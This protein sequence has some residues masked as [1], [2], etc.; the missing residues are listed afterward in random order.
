MSLFGPRPA[1]T[2]E[3][4]TDEKIAECAVRSARAHLTDSTIPVEHRMQW[5][6]AT[7]NAAVWMIEHP[8]TEEQA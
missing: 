5:A 1:S 4:L 7:L 3:V 6:L 2:P 8:P